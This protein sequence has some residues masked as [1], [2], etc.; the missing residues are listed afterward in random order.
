MPDLDYGKDNND[1][2]LDD[3]GNY[4]EDDDAENSY[5]IQQKKELAIRLLLHFRYLYRQL[6]D[7]SKKILSVNIMDFNPE[8]FLEIIQSVRDFYRTVVESFVSAL[9]NYNDLVGKYGKN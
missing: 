5:E 2:P 9:H 3:D 4:P 6:N 7:N 8:G 1:Y